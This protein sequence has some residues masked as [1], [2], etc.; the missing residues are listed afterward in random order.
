MTLKDA[1]KSNPVIYEVVPPRRDTSRYGTELRGVE[2][3]LQDS[4]I[5][6]VNIPE[7]T[8]RREDG[9]RV[10]YSPATIPPEEYAAMV[11][12]RKEAIVNLI[13][14]RLEREAFLRRARRVLREYGV[15]NLVVVGKE[16]REDILPGPGVEEALGLLARE[17]TQGTALGGIC[18]FSRESS[19]TGEGGEEA[20]RVPEPL[21]VWRKAGAGC[22]FVT[23]QISFEAGPATR[24][25]REYQALCDK[26]GT[27]PLTVFVSLA[28]VPTRSIMS[29]LEGLDVRVPLVVKE[30]LLG[31]SD[32]GRESVKV[33][34]EVLREIT[35]GAERDGLRVP[36]GVQ[37]EQIGV[38]NDE[39]SL[40]LLDEVHE[41]I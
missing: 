14:P 23:S 11:V 5:A 40:E 19:G 24:F 35:E 15:P 25:L 2:E 34:A 8:N 9:G 1:L 37:I 27:E 3:V 13:A 41:G 38:S 28:T 4:R 20:R 31:R 30:R 18:I 32:M 10:V 39:L 12:E 21:R 33:E 16:R 17:R 6:A 36:L 29:L 26:R 7:L 22:D